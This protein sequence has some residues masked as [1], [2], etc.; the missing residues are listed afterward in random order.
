MLSGES[1]YFTNSNDITQP[2]TQ[3]LGL[4]DYQ[5]S[6]DLQKMWVE[7]CFLRRSWMGKIV[8]LEHPNT[9]TLGIRGNNQLD[10]LDSDYLNENEFKIHKSPR[11]GEAVLHSPGQ[12]VI[13]PII[14]LKLVK[15]GAKQ[16]IQWLENSTIE[17]LKEFGINS[18]KQGC[19]PGIYT[20]QGKI[21]MIGVKISRGITSHGIAINLSN[22]LG[23]FKAIRCCG[24]ANSRFDSVAHYKSV[25]SIESLFNKWATNAIKMLLTSL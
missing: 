17:W 6:C 15:M 12:L 2:L 13:Y 14:N 24:V 3:W 11:G 5:K 1:F 18:F 9:V 22:Q 23:H 8:G 25:N 7:E 4:V 16:Y 21:A 20:K 10:I 19:E